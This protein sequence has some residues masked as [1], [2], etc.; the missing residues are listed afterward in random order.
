MKTPSPDATLRV[1]LARRLLCIIYDLLLILALVFLASIPPVLLLSEP[2][3][4]TGELQPAFYEGHP[5]WR[6]GYFAY[7]AAVVF[8]FYGWFWTHGGQSL[9]MK[10]WGVRVEQLDG[11]PLTWGLALKRYLWAMV[12]WALIGGGFLLSLFRKDGMTLHDLYSGTRLVRTHH[13]QGE[14]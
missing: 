3:T 7:L 12:S 9:G 11:R 8:V 4:G 5:L 14:A 1:S 10:T 13:K 6:V 2:A